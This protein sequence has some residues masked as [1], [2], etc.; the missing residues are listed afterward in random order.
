M[1]VASDFLLFHS[2]PLNTGSGGLQLIGATYI[3]SYF[4]MLFFNPSG[5]KREEDAFEPSASLVAAVMVAGA[6]SMNGVSLR[7]GQPLKM[8]DENQVSNLPALGHP[9]VPSTY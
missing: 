8:F 1:D 5:T 4:L 2:N 9:E 7:D 3:I 6:S